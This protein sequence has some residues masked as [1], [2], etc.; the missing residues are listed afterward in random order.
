MIPATAT[1]S[2]LLR[3][4]WKVES[5]GVPQVKLLGL[6]VLLVKIAARPAEALGQPDRLETAGPVTR[7]S[8]VRLV[9]ETFHQQHRMA[10]PLLPVGA[11]APQRQTQNARG[12]I[13][14][15]LA[16]RPH[17]KPA[18]VDDQP[19][20]AGALT[21]TPANPSL[22]RL[23]VQR[24][25]T[26]R[27]QRDPLPVDLGHIPQRLSGQPAA[28]KIMLLLEM[29]VEPAHFTLSHE[30]NPHPIQNI[31]LGREIRQNHGPR[32]ELGPN[33]VQSF[34]TPQAPSP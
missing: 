20:P 1:A 34:L 4:R 7:A 5:L 12:Q 9:D 6:A 19:E 24:R 8:V 15:A 10:P 11:Q 16:L 17:Q 2:A 31:T 13:G 23:E 3:T 18:V 33:N 32:V 29:V 22:P 25:R 14:M 21:R 30:T 26:E 27:Q 28:L